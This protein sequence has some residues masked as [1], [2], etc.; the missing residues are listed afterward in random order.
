MRRANHAA[1]LVAAGHLVVDLGQDVGGGAVTGAI[2]LLEALAAVLV[3]PFVDA[4]Q[5]PRRNLLAD[6][7][8]DALGRIEKGVVLQTS[9][10]AKPAVETLTYPVNG[11][12]QNAALAE[13]VGFVFEL[14]R[15]LEGAGRAEG[16]SPGQG[17]IG[18]LPVDVLMNGEAA[19]DPGAVDVAALLVKPPHR[20]PHPL[21]AHPDDVDVVAEAFAGAIDVGHQKTMRQPE[22]GARSDRRHDP[23]II[24]RLCSVGDQQQDEVGVGDDV[25][26]L[27][28]RPVGLGK[29]RL[30]DIRNR[31]RTGPQPN[32]DADAAAGERFSEILRLGWSL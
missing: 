28:A 27:A 13:D 9:L 10:R 30:F 7:A 11:A 1:D 21:R 26:H 20:R 29:A 6:G 2:G 3:E 16:D 17:I 24:L 22:S 25:V 32:L 14:E 4:E 12:Q 23:I 19:I 8:G 31:I 5:A 15:R 18:G